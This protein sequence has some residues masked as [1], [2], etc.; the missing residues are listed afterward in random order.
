[1]TTETGGKRDSKKFSNTR[2]SPRA[3]LNEMTVLIPTLGRAILEGTLITLAE[4]TVWPGELILIDQGP[5]ADV[6]GWVANLNQLGL[7]T[8]YFPSTQR[9]RASGINRGLE[10]VRTRFV[11][12]TD[13]D[14]FVAQDWLEKMAAH[15]KENPV[16]VVTGRVEAAGNDMITV[17]TSREPAIYN[18]PRLQF[19]SLSGGNM[20]TSMKVIARIGYFDED[21]RLKTCEDG[22]WAYRA[23]REGVAIHYTPEVVVWH[24]GWRNPDERIVQYRNYARSHGGFYGKYIR[25]GDLFILLRAVIHHLRALM[26]WLRGILRK[27]DELALNGWAYMTGLLPGILAGLKKG[28]KP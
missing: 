19:D 8:T 3:V 22:D 12:I 13:D 27:D 4:G 6:A 23:L 25:K 18:T 9:G 1:M 2:L 17:V 15:L 7:H 14:C 11:A 24:Y 10:R 16:A 26:R 20:G 21:P 5:S 28:E